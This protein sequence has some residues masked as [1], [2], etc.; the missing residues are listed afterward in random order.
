M[1]A[2]LGSYCSFTCLKR[3]TT[4]VL[5]FVTTCKLCQGMYALKQGFLSV[6]ELL[7]AERYWFKVAQKAAF[8]EETAALRNKVEVPRRGCLSSLYPFLD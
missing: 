1:L 6:E 3:F 8:P 7:E 2:M 4:W 5:C